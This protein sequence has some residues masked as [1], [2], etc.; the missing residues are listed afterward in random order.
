MTHGNV[1]TTR[2]HATML[3]A[4]VYYALLRL[5][6]EARQLGRF[7][8][9]TCAG[10]YPWIDGTVRSG[11]S[12][13]PVTYA[14]PGSCVTAK[15]ASSDLFGPLWPSRAGL[16]ASRATLTCWHSCR[17]PPPNAPRMGASMR[18]DLAWSNCCSP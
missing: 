6:H 9:D 17:L 12:R 11:G 13:V 15:M 18:T 3:G 7:Y 16:I 10:N 5:L 8:T 14:T 2:V 4:R 1:A